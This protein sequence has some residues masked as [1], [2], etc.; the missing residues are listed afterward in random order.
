MSGIV[1][2]TLVYGPI[3]GVPQK[4]GP[5]LVA[6]GLGDGLVQHGIECGQTDTGTLHGMGRS[7]GAGWE[8]PI[9]S[10]WI[11]GFGPQIVDGEVRPTL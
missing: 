1:V 7:I 5:A 2:T 11:T 10:R 6:D 8:Q 3:A 4:R 9:D